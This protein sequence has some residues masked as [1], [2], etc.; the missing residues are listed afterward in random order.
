MK[1]VV[2]G[3]PSK[4]SYKELLSAVQVAF[5]EDK[6]LDLSVYDSK[7]FTTD[8]KNRQAVI[9]AAQ[10]A[11]FDSEW[12]DSVLIRQDVT[13]A[14]KCGTDLYLYRAGQFHSW[15]IVKHEI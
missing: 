4:E 7:S 10:M 3:E 6:V 12:E 14:L 5:P 8:Q 1:I 15:P 11:V 9:R 2:I 13:H